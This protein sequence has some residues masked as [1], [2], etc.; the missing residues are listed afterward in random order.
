MFSA[1]NMHPS[2]PNVSTL[3]Y[4]HRIACTIMRPLVLRRW[5]HGDEKARQEAQ[6][7]WQVQEGGLQG[8][9][10]AQEG[11]PQ[12]QDTEGRRIAREG[13][14]AKARAQARQEGGREEAGGEASS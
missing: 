4:R 13:H 6:G 7:F 8:P 2:G 9:D 3:D 12:G 10:P 1:I 5:I 11:G 14:R